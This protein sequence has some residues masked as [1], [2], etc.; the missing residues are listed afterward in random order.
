[1]PPSLEDE[2]FEDESFEDGRAGRFERRVLGP[3]REPDPRYSLANERTFLAWIRTS[4]TL[5][6]GGVAIEAFAGDAFGVVARRGLALGLVCLGMV[7]AA[8]SCYRWVSL[9]RAM[10]QGRPLPLNPVGLALAAGVAIAAAFLAVSI[11]LRG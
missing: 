3:G 6:G 2:S 9:E 4:L 1:M 10:R 11:A 7:L 5:L 8:V